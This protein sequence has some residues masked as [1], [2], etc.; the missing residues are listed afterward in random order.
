MPFRSKAQ[1]RFLFAKH[2]TIAKRWV[3]ES[4]KKHPIKGLPNK[5]RRRK[6]G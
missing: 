4:G 1:A 3:R 6:K 5:K 2:P